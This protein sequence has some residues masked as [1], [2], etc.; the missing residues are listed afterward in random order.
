MP[1]LP[2]APAWT[3]TTTEKI[4]HKALNLI[5]GCKMG[6]WVSELSILRGLMDAIG[7][8]IWRSEC[9]HGV[10]TEIVPVHIPGHWQVR[11]VCSDVP[12]D[13]V[14]LSAPRWSLPH[15]N[16]RP[17]GPI[18]RDSLRAKPDL[19]LEASVAR[20]TRP[21]SADFGG[22]RSQG[23]TTESSTRPTRS[24]SFP[25]TSYCEQVRRRARNTSCHDCRRPQANRRPR[26][27]FHA[28][29]TGVVDGRHAP[30]GSIWHRATSCPRH[31][32]A[33]H[34]LPPARPY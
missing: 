7:R 9:R 1:I 27:E 26:P 33:E 29:V 28:R 2:N 14:Q 25:S 24:P 11:Q 4:L 23:R 3:R 6:P 22:I 30:N 10:A 5:H 13:E 19:A 16:G 34:E 21:A 15:S 32:R 31:E 12:I 8:S 17:P 18:R 20:P